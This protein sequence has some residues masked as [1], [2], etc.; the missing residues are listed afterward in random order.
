LYPHEIAVSAANDVP[1]TANVA[2]IVVH[3]NFIVSLKFVID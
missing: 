1:V 2:T 3:S